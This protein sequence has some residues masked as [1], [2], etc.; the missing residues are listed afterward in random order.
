MLRE[1]AARSD[2]PVPAVIAATDDL[3]VIEFIE[4]SGR[5]DARAEAH[6]ADLVAALHAIRGPAF[7]LERDTLIGPLPQPNPEGDDWIAFFR[8]HRLLVMAD[9]AADSGRLP[10]AVRQRIGSLAA[11]LDNRLPRPEHPALLHGDMWGGN[12]LVRD[13]R[14]AGFIDPAIY[15]GEPEIELAFTTLFSTFGEAFFRRYQEHRPLAPGFFGERIMLYNLYPLLVHV[16]LFG[17]G[18]VQQVSGSLDRLGY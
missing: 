16:T 9:R 3:L 11:D 13:G 1:L 15:Y 4:T 12:V 6:A 5:L 17:G 7:G 10:S 2:L 18:Y 14:I 8:D